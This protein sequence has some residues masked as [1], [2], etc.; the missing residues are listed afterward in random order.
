MKR[1]EK[2]YRIHLLRDVEIPRR[3]PLDRWLT[4]LEMIMAMYRLE[5]ARL[6]EGR[7]FQVELRERP[8]VEALHLGRA[9][10]AIPGTI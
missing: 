4:R 10:V 7:D 1:T 5:D 9:S 3:V 6:V 8:C 2:P